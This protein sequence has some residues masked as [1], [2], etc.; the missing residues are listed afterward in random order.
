LRIICSG[1][2]SGKWHE[3]R[4]D[5]IGRKWAGV[6]DRRVA[7]ESDDVRYADGSRRTSFYTDDQRAAAE[8][9]TARSNQSFAVTTAIAKAGLPTLNNIAALLGLPE[10]A[11]WTPE[12]T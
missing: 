11:A 3:H 9:Y 10:V 6:G 2:R 4:V 1:E 12:Q 8:A 7:I 5:S